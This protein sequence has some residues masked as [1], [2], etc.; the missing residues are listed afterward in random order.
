MARHSTRLFALL[1]VGLLGAA[2]AGCGPDYPE[3][4][5]RYEGPID[6]CDVEV[7]T[8]ASSTEPGQTD[9][10]APGIE[11]WKDGPYDV[12]NTSP[13][14]ECNDD[15]TID[16]VGEQRDVAMYI[17]Y[18][19]TSAPTVSGE[20]DVAPGAWPVIVFAHANNDSKCNIYRDYWSLHDHWASW[21]FVVVSVDGTYTNC[22]PGSRQNIVD[23]KDGQLAAL[24]A[25]ADLNQSSDSRF[26]GRIDLD[27][28]VFAGH[29]RGGGSSLLAARE[30][31]DALGVIDIQGI[32]LTAFG[33]GD[34]P[35]VGFPVVG[36]TAGQDVDLNY[37][38]VEP[39]ED[40]IDGVYTWVNITG[41]IHAYTADAV[42]I[43]PDDEPFIPRPRQHDITEYYSTAFLARFVGVG[44]GA[45]PTDESEQVLYSHHAARQVDEHI[46][47]LAVQQRWRSPTSA[48][49]IDAFD[50]VDPQINA[51]GRANRSES[52]RTSDETWTYRPDAEDPGWVYRKAVSRRLVADMPGEFVLEIGGDVAMAPGDSLQARVKGPDSGAPAAFDVRVELAD[53]TEATV[54]GGQHIGP[55]LLSNRFTQLVVDAEELGLSSETQVDRVVF[56]VRS[57]TLFVDDVR[58]VVPDAM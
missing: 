58:V 5:E 9:R 55:E 34:D 28:V 3:R 56:E 41:G 15:P 24:D 18:P 25:L 11:Y 43:E 17:T 19:T 1:F 20:G 40:Q 22:Q 49:L 45:Y 7:A 2:L 27:R 54:E 50:G 36:F 4:G 23:R 8:G 53:G 16:A 57:G 29:S 37:P 13:L 52:L 38:I 44:S 48:V 14:D 6:P 47:P 51:L 12:W 31:G 26:T 46:S 30:H 21:G 32:D 39:T 35:I 42:P 10:N 33:F